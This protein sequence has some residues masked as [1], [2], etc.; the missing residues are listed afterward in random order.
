MGLI[1]KI[2]EI[3]ARI[4]A[5]RRA[6]HGP[7]DYAELQMLSQQWHRAMDALRRER[8]PVVTSDERR[9]SLRR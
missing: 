4:A 7:D 3:G 9:L 6:L 2:D 1:G 5:V 8:D